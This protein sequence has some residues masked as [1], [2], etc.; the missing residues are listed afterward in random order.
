MAKAVLSVE[1][2]AKPQDS[3]S[4]PTA[5]EVLKNLR[6]S[7]VEDHFTVAERGGDLSLSLQVSAEEF[8]RTGNYYVYEGAVD[9]KVVSAEMGHP[10]GDRRFTARAPRKLGQAAAQRQLGVELAKQIAPWA[11]ETLTSLGSGMAVADLVVPVRWPAFN[12]Q[13]Y[14][15]QLLEAVRGLD[16]VRGAH[17]VDFSRGERR[18]A[19]RTLYDPIRMP[20][21]LLFTLASKHPELKLRLP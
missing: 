14:A 13:A 2:T 18:I 15:T 8:D 5:S 4:E 20:D 16:G 10:F 12:Q 17:L 11:Q 1:L 6:S 7:L 3:A 21:G 9:A 19:I